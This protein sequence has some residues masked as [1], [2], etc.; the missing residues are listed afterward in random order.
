M[1]EKVKKAKKDPVFNFE[2]IPEDE[3]DFFVRNL[4]KRNRNITKKMKEIE[5]LETLAETKELKPEQQKKV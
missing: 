4:E 3:K 5:S 1:V 2:S